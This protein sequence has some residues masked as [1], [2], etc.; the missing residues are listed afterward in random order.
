ML[1]LLSPR[2][3]L[4]LE[5]AVLPLKL[6]VHPA[7]EVE[8]PYHVHVALHHHFEGSLGL[9]RSIGH[10]DQALPRFLCNHKNV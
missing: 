9:D 8:L 3:S 7:F 4:P 2:R 10:I 5:V 6:L 1:L